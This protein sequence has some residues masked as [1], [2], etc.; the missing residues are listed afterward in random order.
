MSE[1]R[2]FAIAPAAPSTI[3]RI[4]SG[5]LSFGADMTLANNPLELPV[6]RFLNIDKEPDYLAREALQVFRA[7]GVRQRLKGLVL[8]GD[9]LPSNAERWPVATGG[10]VIGHVTSAAYSPRQRRN[11]A[12]AMLRLPEADAGET[13]EVST[14]HG[15]RRATVEELPFQWSEKTA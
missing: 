3:E 13:V 4:E 6:Q 1:G 14:P 5:L 8:D 9:A 10:E 12:F 15:T 11:L 7:S 2:D